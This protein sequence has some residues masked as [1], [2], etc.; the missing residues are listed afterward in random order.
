[1]IRVLSL[2]ALLA[3]ALALRLIWVLLIPVDPVS[4]AAA[5]EIFARNLAEHGV[6]GFTPDEPG[7]Y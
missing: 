4:D 2:P 5:Y 6:F 1:M 3:L 7:A